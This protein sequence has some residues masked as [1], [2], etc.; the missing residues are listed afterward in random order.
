MAQIL[1]T[2][3]GVEPVIFYENCELNLRA[4]CKRQCIAVPEGSSKFQS[5][6]QHYFDTVILPELTDILA[7]FQYSYPVW[8]NHLT[9]NQQQE[10]DRVDPDNLMPRNCSIFCKG[11]KQLGSTP[12]PKNRCI[13]A[14]NSNHKYVLGPVT[15]ALEQYLKNLKGYWGGKNWDDL[16]KVYDDWRNL[17]ATIIALDIKGCDR[18]MKQWIKD[19][20]MSPVYKLVEPFV[21]HVPLDVYKKHAYPQYTKLI[22]VQYEN[23][24]KISLGDA[25]IKGTMLSG[26]M[27]TKATNTLIVNVLVR[28]TIE[29]YITREYPGL[30]SCG[31]DNVSALP[32]MTPRSLIISAFSRT[33]YFAKQIENPYSF[34]YFNHGSGFILK[35]LQICSNTED[36][37]FCS[38]NVFF[39]ENCKTHRVTRK[40][41]RFIKLSPWSASVL[42]LNKLQRQGYCQNLY[43]SNLKWMKNLA[44][45]TPLNDFLTY[46]QVEYY[47]LEGKQKKILPLTQ[48]EMSW[49]DSFL[50]IA[51]HS[52]LLRQFGK[53]NYYSMLN[54]GGSIKSCCPVYYNKWLFS[55][56]GLDQYELSVITQQITSAI[57]SYDSPL[58]LNALKYHNDYVASQCIY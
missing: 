46:S 2:L 3:E 47:T 24:S 37:D 42:S 35:Y 30:I 36:I 20:I 29:T 43:T 18:S 33:F 32:P 8:Y 22:A 9:A 52:D 14:M 44:I 26:D 51:R 58:L 39:C 16:A 45:F 1:P 23:K 31:D 53:E 40:L 38:T 25:T 55:H 7:D 41:D 27:A 5:E 34:C 49:R 54:I 10:M 11:E 21:Y 19:M 28:F 17:D 12:P 56:F 48:D 6:L 13:C 15:Y 50:P 57:N 4:A